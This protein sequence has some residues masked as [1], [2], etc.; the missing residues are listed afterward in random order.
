[1]NSYIYKKKKRKHIWRKRGSA[2]IKE[3]VTNE[4][5]WRRKLSRTQRILTAGWR[6]GKKAGNN[7]DK[8]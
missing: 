4:G 6:R 3:R 7:E 5:R 2:K 8:T 1:L